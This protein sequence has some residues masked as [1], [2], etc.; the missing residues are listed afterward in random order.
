MG[1]PREIRLAMVDNDDIVLMGLSAILLRHLPNA[2]LA[3]K[4]HTGAEALDYAGDPAHD[5]DILLVD[6]SLEDMP[7]NTVC[8]EIRRR[9]GV[10]PLLA[11]TSFSLSRYAVRAC[12]AGAQ[13]I[14]SKA[15]FTLLCKA[16]ETVR[17]GRPLPVRL[18]GELIAF[19]DADTAHRRLASIP[20][21]DVDVLSERERRIV[22]WYAQARKPA[23][24]ADLMG[25]S[26]GTVKTHLER[27]RYK[28]GLDSRSELIV[29]WW[30]RE[31]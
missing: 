5:A 30:S 31:R 23:D 20:A 3:W 12:E 27:A 25:I 8:R 14:V 15:D 2:R 1:N 29:Y 22:E 6:M 10:L 18:G 17:G 24:I 21:D 16:V 13:G 4:A 11:M 26:V 9:D 7:G 19:E 28:L